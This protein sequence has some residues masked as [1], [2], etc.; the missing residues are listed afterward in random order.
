[1]RMR[2]LAVTAAIAAIPVLAWCL[3]ATL[4]I[5]SGNVEEFSL[6]YAALAGV[7][8]PYAIALILLLGLP[9][10]FLGESALSLYR[11]LLAALGVLAWLQGN[12]LVWDYGVLDGRTIDWLDG[13]WRGVLELGI[14][15]V[16]ISIAVRGHARFGKP[17]VAAAVATFA[18][19]AVGA[20]TI[21]GG[22]SHSLLLRDAPVTT[23]ENRDD[24]F[25]FSPDTNV[26]HIVL[27]GLQTDIFEDILATD[28]GNQLAAAL[29]G[30]TLY[31]RH[32]GVYPY[33]QATVPALLTGR[34][35]TNEVPLDDFIDTALRGQTILGSALDAGFEVDIAAPG[36]WLA[37]TYS[38]AHHTNVYGILPNE[39]VN[40]SEVALVEASRLIDLALFRVV[41]HF[42]R[43]LVYRDELWV[44]QPMTQSEAYLHMQYFSDIAFL[45]R[46]ADRMRVDRAGRVYKMMHLML[47]HKP[48]VATAE[49]GYE[50]K[51]DSSRATVVAHST[52][53]LR[54][55][56]AVLERMQEL[57]IYDNS[58]I[59]L[60]ADH[61]AWVPVTRLRNARR[62]RDSISA[63]QV[64]MATPLL[65]IKPPGA[66][67]TLQR[68]RKETSIIDIPATIADVLGLPP[69]FPGLSALDE[70]DS[71]PRVRSHMVYG[72]GYYDEAPGYLRP[73]QEYRVTGDP[74]DAASW[75]L[76][77]RFLPAGVVEDTGT[78]APAAD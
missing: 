48:F 78:A 57:G 77:R 9:G 17:L 30:F 11:S 44:F 41:P 27:D 15:I 46:L 47:S 4:V 16:L 35:F 59:V 67:G 1:M 70:G 56:V 6:G 38:K 25:G 54:K 53:S 62:D 43:P 76:G 72:Y 13:A 68:S 10:A 22:A 28:S 2:D 61:G 42:V 37:H 51:K 64:A 29:D 63:L 14:W 23:Q 65:A 21:L 26:V 60:M 18:I 8:V 3:F 12:I 34:L 71:A 39:H 74:Y 73:M 24:V 69:Q 7:Y 33:T 66:S 45:D 36:A 5:Y 55:V 58:L 75:Q 32:L 40:D 49:C 19:Q 31:E 50:G 52:C 20:V